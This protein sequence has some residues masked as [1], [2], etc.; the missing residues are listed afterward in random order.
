MSDNNSDIPSLESIDDTQNCRLQ[1]KIVQLTCQVSCQRTQLKFLQ[2]HIEMQNELLR[3]LIDF[4]RQLSNNI[5]ER[6]RSHARP[7]QMSPIAQYNNSLGQR[8]NRGRI[9][10][11]RGGHTVNNSCHVTPRNRPM[12]TRHQPVPENNFLGFDN[13]RG[14]ITE[15]QSGTE[16]NYLGYNICDNIRPY[17]QLV[18]EANS[19]LDHTS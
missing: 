17:H 4:S 12:S 11:Q 1:N 13:I 19:I 15:H 6:D 8:S 14:P 16:N 18:H 7:N 10:G 5:C 3:N 2:Q 9:R